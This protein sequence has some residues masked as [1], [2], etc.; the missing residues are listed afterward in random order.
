M[1]SLTVLNIIG[2]NQFLYFYHDVFIRRWLRTGNRKFIIIFFSQRTF[3]Y[4]FCGNLIGAACEWRLNGARRDSIA[5]GATKLARLVKNGATREKWRDSW[6]MARLAKNGVTR[7]TNG[8]T[9][10]QMAKLLAGFSLIWL[11]INLV[12]SLQICIV[13]LK[14]IYTLLVESY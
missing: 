12:F 7:E 11:S 9:F 8:K 14:K 10:K 13:F 4:I 1:R 5:R 2:L 3:T 6:K